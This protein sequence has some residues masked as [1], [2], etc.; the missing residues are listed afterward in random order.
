MIHDK[1]GLSSLLRNPRVSA[2]PDADAD[3]P[4]RAA[5][6]PP[7][8]LEDDKAERSAPRTLP[9]YRFSEERPPQ[10]QDFGLAGIRKLT[11]GDGSEPITGPSETSTQKGIFVELDG[12]G[13][14]VRWVAAQ[15]VQW[16]QGSFDLLDGNSQMMPKLADDAMTTLEAFCRGV[17]GTPPD[18]PISEVS[19][20]TLVV[21]LAQRQAQANGSEELPMSID[22][23][24]ANEL[25]VEIT[26]TLQWRL[27][28]LPYLTA[29]RQMVTT[30]NDLTNRADV[31]G[32]TTKTLGQGA[33]LRQAH[34]SEES[35]RGGGNLGASFLGISLGAN[36]EST[37]TN[38]DETDAE[39]TGNAELRQRNETMDER[40]KT[41]GVD[42]MEESE[43]RTAYADWKLVQVMRIDVKGLS[44][45]TQVLQEIRPESGGRVVAPRPVWLRSL[46]HVEKVLEERGD[47]CAQQDLPAAE[48]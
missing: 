26:K 18:Q 13:S 39:R 48:A 22:I 24:D 46:K 16:V 33:R 10:L 19:M 29:R 27:A 2:P 45:L 14:P 12:D 28:R 35:D 3:A 7:D 30:R 15:V 42:D 31:T 34:T 9:T 37:T 11:G 21:N 43:P 23:P 40:M 5:P 1:N 8:A 25:T 32:E 44:P 38:R 41:K 4:E 17:N 47:S 6:P 20:N 36:F